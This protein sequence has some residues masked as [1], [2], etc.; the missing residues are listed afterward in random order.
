MVPVD[1]RVDEPAEPEEMRDWD[2]SMET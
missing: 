1:H 2:A